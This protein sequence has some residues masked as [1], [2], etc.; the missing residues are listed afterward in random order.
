VATVIRLTRLGS[1]RKPHH[2]IVV[3]DHHR[4]RDGRFIEQVGVYDPSKKPALVAVQTERVRY[5]LSTGARPTPTVKSIFKQHNI[6]PA[7]AAMPKPAAAGSKKAEK[8]PAK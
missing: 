1:K 2:K 3:T 4:P 5:W 7:K 6:V 8:R